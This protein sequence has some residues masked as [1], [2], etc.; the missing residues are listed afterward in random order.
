MRLTLSLADFS[1]TGKNIGT[2]NSWFISKNT[3][4]GLTWTTA[5]N[6]VDKGADFN[7]VAEI[8]T[9][10][11]ELVTMTVTMGTATQTGVGTSGGIRIS[12]SGSQYTI[13]ISSVTANVNISVTTKNL[14]TGLPDSGGSGG[15]STTYTFTVNPTPSTATVTLSA[16]GYTTVTGTGSKSITVASGTIVSWSVSAS[17]YTSQNGTQNVIGTSSKSVTLVASGGTST[18]GTTWYVDHRNQAESFTSSVN[19]AGRGWTHVPGTAAYNAYVGKPVNTVG[20]YTTLASQNITIGKVAEKGGEAD[21][22]T[23]ATVTAT[24]PTGTTKGFCSVTFPTVTLNSG[25]CLVI[26]AQTDA[27][28][29]FFYNGNA[30]VTDANG[31]KDANFY[32]RVPKVYG[33][34]TAWTS[35]S[36]KICLGLSVGYNSDV[37]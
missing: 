29:N 13:Y 15:G 23:I 33:S 22:T 6:S 27:N 7:A 37:A 20:F 4:S 34:G 32:G 5:P 35:Y 30:S 12:N 1:G 8:D 14:S 36:E 25:E 9:A 24:N 11:Y 18:S 28:I 2:L 31:I 3:P 16:T 17:G 26:F 21:M 10:N 19:I